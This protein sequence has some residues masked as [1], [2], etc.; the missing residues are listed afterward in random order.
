MEFIVSAQTK[1]LDSELFKKETGCDLF[2]RDNNLI[3]SGCQNQKAA[4]ELIEK[5]N[6]PAPKEI[7]IEQKLASVGLNIDDLKAALGL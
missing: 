5:H 7:T 2:V 1:F 6:P 3:V 4:D